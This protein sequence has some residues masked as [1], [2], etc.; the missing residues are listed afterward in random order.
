MNLRQ[1]ALAFS[2]ALSVLSSSASS[3]A[4][5]SDTTFVV[6]GATLAATGYLFGVLPA[7]SPHNSAAVYLPLVGP[8]VWWL[9]ANER[10][11]TR[12]RYEREHPCEGT[13][14]PFSCFGK[15]TADLDHA[16]ALT[17]GWLIGRAVAI[18]T[19]GGAAVTGAV[20]SSRERPVPRD[21]SRAGNGMA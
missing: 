19:V 16:E 14:E 5:P 1:S 11:A 20:A 17:S 13:G 6:G 2:L 9:S 3:S 21:S 8:S 15:D 18:T 7:L 12:M 10:I 4:A